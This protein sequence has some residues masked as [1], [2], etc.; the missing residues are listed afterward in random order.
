MAHTQLTAAGRYKIQTL[1]E[2]G[3]TQEEIAH[4]IGKDQSVVSREL[5]RNR[6]ASSPYEAAHAG[7]LARER[8]KTGRHASKKLVKDTVLRD[9]IVRCLKRKDSPEQIAGA[10]KR[11]GETTV[12]HET[13][14][15]FVYDE[16]PELKKYLR[17]KKGRWRRRRG[18]KIREERREQVKKRRIDVRPPEV[19]LRKEIGHWEGDTVRGQEKIQGVATHVER[20]SGYGIGIK[21]DHVTARALREQSVTYFK[22]IPKSKR[23]TETFDNGNEFAEYELIEEGTGMTVY[24]AHPY[25]SWERGTNE[26]WNGLL[27]EFFPK[28]S[29]FA[30]VSQKDVDRAVWNLNHRPRKRLHY[31]TPHEV[32]VK[33]LRP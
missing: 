15:R 32:F 13:I 14:Y 1:H 30:T 20:A 19:A 4:R 24:F 16:A 33:G 26:N 31:L 8:R 11:H 23:L 2:E 22:K 28:G 6:G 18:T 9:A 29:K 5:R 3:Y 17:S 21:L 10:R 12:T 27:R 7:R 25:H